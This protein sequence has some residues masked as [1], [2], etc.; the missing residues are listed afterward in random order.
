MLVFC[1]G[2]AGVTWNYWQAEAA[3]EDLEANLYFHRIA[4]AHRA[5]LAD[6]LGEAHRLLAACPQRLR[7]WEWHYLERLS[8]VDPISLK[9]PQ[10]AIFSIAFSHDGRQIASAQED[11]RIGLYSV[12]TEKVEFLPGHQSHAFSVVFHPQGK[13]LASAG[14]DSKIKLWDLQ[15]RQVIFEKTGHAGKSVGLAGALAFTPDGRRLAGPSGNET[16][17]VWSVPDGRDLFSLL[18]HTKLVSA[19]AFSPRDGQFLAIGDHGR[20]V[21]IYDAHSKKLLRELR[22]HTGPISG[23]A[24][25]R[26]GRFLSAASYDRSARV[27]E[28]S[29]GREVATLRGH[30]GLVVGL[31]FSRDGRRLVTAGGDDK[32]VRLW[33]LKSA[34]QVL[35]LRGETDF[36]ECVAIS[37]DGLR[38]ASA[39]RDGTIRIW[40]ATP[41]EGS[42]GLE[43]LTLEHD[44][45]VWSASYSPDGRRIASASWDQ[46][47]RV[48]DADNGRLVS[49]LHHPAAVFHVAFNPQHGDQ[50]ATSVR[51]FSPMNSA[52]Y[53]WNVSS[54]H[55][56]LRDF[57][58]R[59]PDKDNPHCVTFS[60]DGSYLLKGSNEHQIHVWDT[61]N[62]G[63]LGAFG[64]HAYEIRAVKFS[65]DGTR[66][67]SAS[68]DGAV[69]IWKW[70]PE[71]LDLQ[72]T[73]PQK[74][75]VELDVKSTGYADRIAFSADGRRLA[76]AGKSRSVQ[77]WDASSG[78]R[79]F[80][81]AGH[82]GD[83]YS[84]A[85]S[86][87]GRLLA[88]GGEDTT[89]RLWDATV[90]PYRP[91]KKLRGHFGLIISL[92]FSPDSRRLVSGS[93]DATVK[94]WDLPS[95]LRQ[96][97]Q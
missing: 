27:W 45:E 4:L 1:T 53:L 71:G 22:G 55:R 56:D 60:P 46:T 61:T 91:L 21:T 40:D 54:R 62:Q 2:F 58:Q 76:T 18:R 9:G 10:Q 12:D 19:V 72:L 29:S 3:R 16:V 39:G 87:D 23:I 15:A 68:R 69:K 77:V 89:V 66:V 88:T 75:L 92:A 25:S 73:V 90:D 6:N 81:L 24:F 34:I 20:N 41:L 57:D 79:L 63:W 31:V 11:G 35:N 82:T 86:P 49:M 70:D 97:E 51:T 43:L 44:E 78:T 59:I 83:V 7:D 52:I 37:P 26:D 65:P 8:K 84:F 95:I 85:F 94:V 96:L 74:P 42:E 36:G 5:I 50:L 67:A 64:Q 30:A 33:D 47:A 93:R 13:Y 48:W 17:T 80:S 38:L 14:A 28:V 32:A